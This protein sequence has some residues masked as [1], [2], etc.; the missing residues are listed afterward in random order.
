MP[1]AGKEQAKE[2]VSKKP[3]AKQGK[4]AGFGLRRRER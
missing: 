4:S 3:A 1:I 2:A